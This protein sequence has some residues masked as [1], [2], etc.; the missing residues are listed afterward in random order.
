MIFF[1]PKNE[2]KGQNGHT[3]HDIC[4]QLCKFTGKC[5]N[6]N[7]DAHRDGDEDYFE[8]YVS[9]FK[10]FLLECIIINL[11][12]DFFEIMVLMTRSSGVRAICQHFW[13]SQS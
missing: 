1:T 6:K 8:Y 9:F 3:T 12:R 10:L 7:D 5:E 2:L 4:T 11:K 13:I